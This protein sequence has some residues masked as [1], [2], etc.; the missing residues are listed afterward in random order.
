[1]PDRVQREALEWLRRAGDREGLAALSRLADDDIRLAAHR[2]L[3]PVRG[4]AREEYFAH[5]IAADPTDPNLAGYLELLEWNIGSEGAQ[6]LS[7]SLQARL[8]ERLRERPRA[9]TAMALAR[10][11]H[12]DLFETAIGW[13]F[14]GTG[15]SDSQHRAARPRRNP[16]AHYGTLADALELCHSLAEDAS[17]ERQQS[18]LALARLAL[19]RGDLQQMNDWLIAAGQAPV[20]LRSRAVFHAPPSDWGDLAAQWGPCDE[21]VRSGSAGLRVRVERDGRP[22][23][24]IHLL[25]QPGGGLQR[26][27]RTGTKIDTLLHANEP[28]GVYYPVER[29]FGY[30]ADGTRALT[31]YAV[32]DPN[33]EA[34]F[35]G[36]RSGS[37]KLEIVVPAGIFDESGEQWT[38]FL[39]SADGLRPFGRLSQHHALQREVHDVSPTPEL[40]LEEGRIHDFPVVEIHRAR[41]FDLEHG[42]VLDSAGFTL[43]W[44]KGAEV[45]RAVLLVRALFPPLRP[46]PDF[47]LWNFDPL[48]PWTVPVEGDQVE[49][50]AA[51]VGAEFL[52]PGN[53]LAFELREY[54]ED[55]GLVGVIPPVGAHVPWSHRESTFQIDE[56]VPA[57]FHSWNEPFP[58]IDD[59]AAVL[60]SCERWLV[61]HEGDFYEEYVQLLQA[62]QYEKLGDRGRADGFRAR[63]REVAIVGSVLHALLDR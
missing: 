44:T 51:G 1:M 21:M 45:A 53:L 19:L 11:I 63:L 18:A 32:T 30:D 9:R 22:Q 58:S 52:R 43:R 37:H 8:H 5:R 50:S 10:L 23:E 28:L 62:R 46:L 31:R 33:G 2:A 7:R 41:R 61:E 29:L 26:S 59:P 20:D 38:C 55:G 48:G 47:T 40:M 36:L 56:R 3:A 4:L 60:E 42:A 57:S 12:R 27:R 6:E 15:Y 17:V 24:G 34:L 54:A 39:R 13:S 16:E 14:V 25:V 35:Q 49:L